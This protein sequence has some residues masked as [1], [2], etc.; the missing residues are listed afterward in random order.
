[1]KEPYVKAKRFSTRQKNFRDENGGKICLE[2]NVIC[3]FK[4][5]DGIYIGPVAEIDS[6]EKKQSSGIS[7][8]Y[9]FEPDIFRWFIEKNYSGKE[10][11]EEADRENYQNTID[12]IARLGCEE[13]S[14][15]ENLPKLARAVIRDN[16]FEFLSYSREE[17]SDK[18]VEQILEIKNRHEKEETEMVTQ[19]TLLKTFNFTEKMIEE[20][21]PEPVLVKNPHYASAA[22]MKLFRKK[23]LERVMQSEEYRIQSEKK[24]RR[25][26]ASLEIQVR[27]EQEKQ[28]KEEAY[29]IEREI[30]KL[31]WKDVLSSY[32]P[33]QY[34]T[35][36]RAMSR[37]FIIHAGPTNSG[38][39]HSAM[40]KFLSAENGIYLA[41]LR[42]LA[43]ETAER[44]N[45]A[46]VLCS[47]LT[48]EERN[49]ISEAHHMSCTVEM[50]DLNKTYQVAIID[51]AQ[52]ITD[53]QRGGAWSRALM[54][55]RAAEIHLCCAE[56]A[57][58]NLIK[59]I[60]ECRDTWEVIHHQ[61][62]TELKFEYIS[63]NLKGAQKGDAIIVFS[64]RAVY[65]MAEN[66]RQRGF[67]PALLYGAMPYSVKLQEARRFCS[68]EAD[69][70]V[71][72]DCIGMG[73]NLPVRRIVFA[74][75]EKY[76]GCLMRDLKPA[77]IQ[78][79]AGR[80]GRYR[81]YDTGYFA[82]SRKLIREGFYKTVRSSGIVFSY[83]PDL[84]KLKGRLSD[85]LDFWGKMKT[86]YRKQDCGELVEKLR[87]V[88]EMCPDAGREDILS[89]SSVPFNFRNPVL[90]SYWEQCVKSR[91]NRKEILEPDLY[92][93][94][95]SDLEL[96]HS[97]L[98]IYC[99]MVP[100]EEDIL[101][102]MRLKQAVAEDIADQ[103]KKMS[104]RKSGYSW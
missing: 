3:H 65:E 18:Q 34:Y 2:G 61:R 4:L 5:P 9:H 42:L 100:D 85:I 31:E 46:G 82:S 101:E 103:L 10:P 53:D 22:P 93:Y 28:R 27:K 16:F 11:G 64:R 84:W 14:D 24:A 77:E 13:Y 67:K 41:P 43:L 20:M 87:I 90:K 52:M 102:G 58:D 17:F 12:K 19:T 68:G 44:A 36:A 69:L 74:E 29:R 47:M 32:N 38:K 66:M 25:R 6:K 79:I 78:Q 99:H 104:S 96:L 94:D 63:E 83:P 1:M 54:G 26:K 51:E 48:G 86:N 23:H 95:L 33:A 30:L 21:L 57:V 92:I 55:L 98:D 15:R 76:D 8:E 40:E 97:M 81:L 72:T 88:E 89:W 91:K 71:A 62:M 35:K 50:A 80:A 75:T 49:L 45:E 7:L 60:D 59:L 37:N 73:L 56:Y 39:T 70:L